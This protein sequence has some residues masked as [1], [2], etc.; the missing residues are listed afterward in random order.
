MESKIK[1][2][3]VTVLNMILATSEL[4]V[5]GQAGPQDLGRKKRVIE[6]PKIENPKIQNPVM[7]LLPP[8]MF[9][10]GVKISQ[11]FCLYFFTKG[12]WVGYDYHDNHDNRI[13]YPA[14]EKK[15]WRR[16]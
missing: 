12:R 1:S 6:T 5:Y 3:M 2:G 15:G 8:G 4:W 10:I 7:G 13:G 16:R 11:V 14:W 9:S